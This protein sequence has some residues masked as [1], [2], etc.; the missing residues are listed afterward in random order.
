VSANEQSK[1]NGGGTRLDESRA[2][3]V[4]SAREWVTR[5]QA[6]CSVSFDALFRHYNTSLYRFLHVRTGNSADAEELCQESWLRA[7]QKLG[8]YDASWKFSTWLFTLAAR[9]TISRNRRAT[10]NSSPI[11]LTGS[12]EIEAGPDVDP[13]QCATREEDRHNLW[14]IATEILGEDQR[15]GLWLRYGEDLSGREIAQVLGRPESSVRVILFRARERLAARLM[16]DEVRANRKR[17]SARS[18]KAGVERERTTESVEE[19]PLEPASSRF[20]LMTVQRPEPTVT[21]E[22]KRA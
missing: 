2:A 6:G 18:N 10:L 22:E 3:A 13:H 9:L 1:E 16:Q 17:S 7:W 19:L 4:L 14:A 5:A 21:P 15:M 20:G 12:E 8:T 11:H